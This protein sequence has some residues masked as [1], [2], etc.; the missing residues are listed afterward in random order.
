MRRIVYMSIGLLCVGLA[1]VGL[2]LPLLPTGDFLLLSLW[3]FSR[4][5]KRLHDWVVNH[6]IFG[7]FVHD[8]WVRGGMTK[9]NKLFSIVA[10]SVTIAAMAATVPWWVHKIPYWVMWTILGAAWAI[11]TWYISSRK[12][13]DPLPRVV[14]Q[15]QGAPGENP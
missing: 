7:K 4:S 10:M 1:V 12:T 11:A 9:R 14:D 15:S 8:L 2:F 5:S 6:K 3:F 13:L